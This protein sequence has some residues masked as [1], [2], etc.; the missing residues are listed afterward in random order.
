MSPI[1]FL[2]TET[3][4]VHPGRQVWEIAMIRCDERGARETSFFVDVDLDQA[5][6]FGLSVGRFYERHP[7]GRWLALPDWPTPTIGRDFVEKRAAANT[8]AQWTHGAHIVGAVPNFDTETLDPLLREHGLIP[9]WS[10]HLVDVEALAAGYLAG[11]AADAGVQSRIAPPW[12]SDDL[13]RA[14]NVEPPGDDE[15]H[16]ALGDARWAMRIYDR[17]MGITR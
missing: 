14:I 3:T 8:V 4:G 13:S 1:V 12:K 5:D 17:V 10:Y 16:T 6:P 11:V 7:I 9:A 2:D 15:R